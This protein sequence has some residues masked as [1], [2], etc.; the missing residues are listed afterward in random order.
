MREK[1]AHR[2]SGVVKKHIGMI[3]QRISRNWIEPANA[4]QGMECILRV[5]L[6]SNGDVK[7]SIVKSSGNAN[8]DRSASSAVNKAAPWPHPGDP[9]V[10]AMFKDFK[11]A[12]RP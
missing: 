3:R 1:E 2:I 5:I 10:A 4:T 7:V 11:F 12:F 9:K 8:F 6:L